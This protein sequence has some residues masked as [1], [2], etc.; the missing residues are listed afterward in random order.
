MDYTVQMYIVHGSHAFLCFQAG[1]QRADRYRQR[2]IS[3][4]I[5]TTEG[6]AWQQLK[7]SS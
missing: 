4:A 6:I 5:W 7:A 3:K 2:A 1:M